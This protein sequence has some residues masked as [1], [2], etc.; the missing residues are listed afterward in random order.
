M[1]D[2]TKGDRNSGARRS[3]RSRIFVK[4]DPTI[5]RKLELTIPSNRRA[6]F[7]ED[8]IRAALDRQQIE[9]TVPQM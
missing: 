3:S 5:K 7:V 1:G 8:A 2:S 6:R 9:S 4:V